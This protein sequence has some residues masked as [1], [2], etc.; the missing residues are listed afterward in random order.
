MH[1]MVHVFVEET[2][3]LDLSILIR[4]QVSLHQ[5]W[6]VHQEL[7]QCQETKTPQMS[8]VHCVCTKHR[9]GRGKSLGIILIC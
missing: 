4:V 9:A 2:T 6:T 7:C 5:C 8:P 3:L 1:T